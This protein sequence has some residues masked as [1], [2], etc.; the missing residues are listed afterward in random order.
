MKVKTLVQTIEMRDALADCL[1]NHGATTRQIKSIDCFKQIAELLRFI[2]TL[3]EHEE[4]VDTR[5][6]HLIL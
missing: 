5:L 3:Y 4:N 2:L 6:L 1:T